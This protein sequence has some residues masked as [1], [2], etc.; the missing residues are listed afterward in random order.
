MPTVQA[1]PAA[2]A[3]LFTS[4]RW[5]SDPAFAG[6]PLRPLLRKNYAPATAI[7]HNDALANRHVLVRGTFCI[8]KPP[9]AALL[10]ITADDYYHLW[11]NGVFVGMGPAAGYPHKYFCNEWAVGPL[12]Q[13]GVN[14]IAV[15]VYYQGLV[16]RVWYS[17]DHRQGLIAELRSGASV[18]A[19][20]DASWRFLVT[21]TYTALGTAGYATNVLERYD[22]RAHPGPWRTTGFDDRAWQPMQVRAD[23]D[24]V[25]VR[26]PTPPLHVYTIFPKVI[27]TIPGGLRLDFGSELTGNLSMRARGASGALI[28]MGFGEELRADGSVRSDMRCNCTYRE[29]WILSGADDELEQFDYKGFRYCEIMAPAGVVIDRSSL[30][31]RARHYRLDKDRF[32]WSS[33]HAGFDAI[34]QLC[35]RTLRFGAQDSILDCPTREKGPYLGDHT[36][37]GLAHLY[38]SGDLP[39]ARKGMADFADSAV[40][41]PGLMADAPCA[42]MQEIADYSLQWPT[43]LWRYYQ[44]SGDLATLQELLPVLTGLMG[45]FATFRRADGLLVDVV[46]KWNIVDWPANLRDGYDFELT[47]PPKPGIHNVINAFYLAALRDA[48]AV[49]AVLKAP[50]FGDE[51]ALREAYRAAFYRPALTLFVDTPTSLHTALQSN[52]MALYAGAAPAAAVPAIVALIR[53]KRFTCGVYM[54]FFLLKALAIAKEWPLIWEL[55]ND[56]GEHSW[57]NMLREGATTTFEAWGKEQKWNTSLCHPWACAPLP[58]VIEDIIGLAPGKPGWTAIAFTPHIPKELTSFALRLRV[59]SGEILVEHKRG[60]TMI[61][62]PN[63]VAV[64][65]A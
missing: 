44:H 22:S 38:A 30:C 63:Q 37:S 28:T 64:T 10:T 16:N 51:A 31:V 27:E 24:H 42:F 23:D 9:G 12:L 17:G 46:D 55:L 18:L 26:Q 48:N 35:L 59:A 11:I 20:S 62:A 7:P 29:E 34:I 39:Y 47:D 15:Q 33:S 61:K 32:H 8:D 53:T 45:H 3:P 2:T 40:I 60:A 50:S 21:R 56:P 52:V 57:N 58:V 1:P 6:Q 54:A 25:L 65:T 41:C 36:I 19:A 4:A 49:A 43:L 13:A 5:I 14:V